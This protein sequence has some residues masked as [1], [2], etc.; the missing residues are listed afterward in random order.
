MTNIG[1]IKNTGNAEEKRNT[2][3]IAHYIIA[4]TKS[5]ELGKTRLNK[6][7]WFADLAHYR[8]YG[9]SM[10]GAT[11]YKKRQFG[12]VPNQIL[13]AL[14]DLKESEIITERT[15]ETPSHPRTEFVW[16]KTPD[17]ADYTSSEVDILH[18]AIDWICGNHS[19]K[20]ISDLTHDALWEE[21]E[22]G[23]EIP[24]GA[25]SVTP[26]E[27]TEDDMSWATRELEKCG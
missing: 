2:A 10:T 1:D 19:A 22:L 21:I 20:S 16:L 7:L 8:R 24:I 5:G 6:V 11:S 9:H 13:A 26:G 4:R 18:E 23:K 17:M 25:A 3:R 14:R 12:P 27:I 15:V